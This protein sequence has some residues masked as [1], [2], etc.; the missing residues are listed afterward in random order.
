VEG[1]F[2]SAGKFETELLGN[3]GG[4]WGEARSSGMGTECMVGYLI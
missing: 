1:D 4:E 2:R 3:R